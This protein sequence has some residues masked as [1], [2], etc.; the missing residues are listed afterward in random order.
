M[1][2]VNRLFGKKDPQRRPPDPKQL[3]RA[4]A[5]FV[6]ASTLIESQSVVE[7]NAILL[8]V[9]R[10]ICHANITN[11]AAVSNNHSGSPLTT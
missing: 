3:V 4:S 9:P 10:Y 6:A 11:S 2:F 5:K 1:S 7:Q 8:R